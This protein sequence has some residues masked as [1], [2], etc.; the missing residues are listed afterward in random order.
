VDNG[1]TILL[2]VLLRDP[3]SGEGGEMGEDS[4]TDPDRVFS[5]TWGVDLDLHLSWGEVDHLLLESLWDTWVHSGTTGHDH[6]LVE[7]FSD[8]NI[9]LHD[10]L[11]GEVVDWWDFA[12]DRTEW[13]K[14]SLWASELLISNGDHVSIWE[15]ILLL[16]S[17]GIFVLLHLLL[18]VKG[19]VAEL[20]LDVSDNFHLGRGGEGWSALSEDLSKILGK[21]STG[22]V[23]SLDSMWQR[24]TLVDW[25]GMGDTITGVD[26]AT[27]DST[28]GVEGQDGLDSNVK[29][30]NVEVFKEDLDHSLSVLLWVS[31]GLS[32]EG[33]LLIWRNTELLIVAVMPDLLHVIPVVDDTVLNWIVELENTSLFL[34]LLTNITIVLL[35]STNLDLMLGVTND[36]WERAFGGLFGFE[37]GFAHTGSI[38]DNNG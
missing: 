2:I 20:L 1:C 6:V 35:G 34:G 32:K 38:I 31:W 12:T 8:I 37:T 30:W 28:R 22:E 17:R 14:E 10:G 15:F 3:H 5:L 7:V 24:V 11:E 27:S 16:F 19:D 29:L 26:D 4:T 23:I 18:V 21:I 33:T 36:G 25:D 13:V 9:A